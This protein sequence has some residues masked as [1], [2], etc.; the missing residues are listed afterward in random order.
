MALKS[1][2]YKPYIY[3]QLSL[4]SNYYQ[5]D[6]STYIVNKFYPKTTYFY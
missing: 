5:I 6:L 3:F 4:I 1:I 2:K